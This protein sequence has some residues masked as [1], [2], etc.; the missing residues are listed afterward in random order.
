MRFPS[1]QRMISTVQGVGCADLQVFYHDLTSASALNVITPAMN[2]MPASAGR[3][4]KKS[5]AQVSE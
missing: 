2:P 5:S 3:K 4:A 1:N